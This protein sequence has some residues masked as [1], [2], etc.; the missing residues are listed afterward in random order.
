M[1]A[2]SILGVGRGTIHRTK[3]LLGLV[4]RSRG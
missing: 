3:M 1:K 4:K 2:L